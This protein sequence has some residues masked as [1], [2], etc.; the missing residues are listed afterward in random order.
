VRPTKPSRVHHLILRVLANR[1]T[2]AELNPL[3][4]SKDSGSEVIIMA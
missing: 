2:Y 3:T 1:Y 4:H